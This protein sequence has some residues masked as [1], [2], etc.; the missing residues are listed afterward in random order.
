LLAQND[1]IQPLMTIHRS[2]IGIF[3]RGAAMGSADVVPG[4]SGGT[5]ALILGIYRRLIEAVAAFD[6]TLLQLVKA[7]QWH[8]AAEHIDLR[9]LAALG[10]GI[11]CAV[12]SLAKLISFL[13][14][15]HPVPTWSFFFGLILAS[16]LLVMRRVERWHGVAWLCAGVGALFAFWLSGLLP[17]ETGGG[18][19]ALFFSGMVAISAMIL[20][21]ISG[22]F[23]LVLLGKYHQVIGAIM[24]LDIP[25]LIVFAAGCGIGLIAF[26]KLLKLLLARHESLTMA[27]LTG[28]ML[29]SLRKV[30]P[31]KSAAP[32][33][34]ALK[35][36]HR[37][38]INFLPDSF[39]EAALW[40]LA[41]AIIGLGAVLLL[42]R[43]GALKEKTH[44]A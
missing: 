21:G 4:V 23:I 35:P 31:F 7:Q 8:R 26:T 3:L 18:Y 17:G 32:G 10:A 1:I 38:Q 14:L 39:D 41:L 36:K 43:L 19:P 22:S 33:Q 29:G 11:G 13:L 27:F 37:V 34:E 2:D 24:A 25:T 20:P 42:E 15:N 28:L 16:T 6:L 5:V 44:A 12:I 9:F 30:W 40:A